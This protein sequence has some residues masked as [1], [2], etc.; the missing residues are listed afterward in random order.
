MTEFRLN[1]YDNIDRSSDLLHLVF[2][3]SFQYY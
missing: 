3:F 2:F 1:Q